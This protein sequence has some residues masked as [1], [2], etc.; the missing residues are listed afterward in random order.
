MRN[1]RRQW[2]W[3]IESKF[4]VILRNLYIKEEKW[5]SGCGDGGPWYYWVSV[6]LFTE[7]CWEIGGEAFAMG[8]KWKVF[9]WKGSWS[10]AFHEEIKDWDIHSW[11]A[12][13][14]DSTRQWEIFGKR[15]RACRDDC[16]KE[17]LKRFAY[18]FG[19]DHYSWAS[20]YLFYIMF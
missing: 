5:L 13:A 15:H 18:L 4:D 14:G 7:R 6:P 10:K 20:K 16:T 9:S 1:N 2:Q 8:K 11:K 19:F 17:E 12:W 3:Y